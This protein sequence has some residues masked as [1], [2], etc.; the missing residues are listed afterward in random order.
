MTTASLTAIKPPAAQAEIVYH[1]YRCDTSWPGIVVI[2]TA[3]GQTLGP[4]R[5]VVRHSPTSLNWGY[6]GSGPADLARSLLIAALGDQAR[7][8]AC[9]GSGK[10][11]LT[12][13]DADQ[14]SYLPE[15]DGDVHPE[16]VLRCVDCDGDGY[17]SLPYHQFKYAHVAK[18]GREWRITRA[19]ILNWL[20]EAI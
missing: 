4:L 3:A 2:E 17:R 6:P 14:R 19:E 11:V 12:S 18:W 10:L 13:D 9:V 5:H 20:A 7:C 8:P 15:R 1:G 16:V